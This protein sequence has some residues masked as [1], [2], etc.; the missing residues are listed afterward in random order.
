MGSILDD[1]IEGKFTRYSNKQIKKNK[2]G[3]SH[4]N[5][6][7]QYRADIA[8]KLCPNCNRTWEQAINSKSIIRHPRGTI[9]TYG[10][11]RQKCTIC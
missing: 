6:T 10:K 7:S 4:V 3:R 11:K 2:T 8:I 5:E 1:Y 9:P